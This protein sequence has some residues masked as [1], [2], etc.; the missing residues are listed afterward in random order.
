MFYLKMALKNSIN[1]MYMN[2]GKLFISSFLFIGLLFVF[3]NVKAK[4][5][6]NNEDKNRKKLSAVTQILKSDHYA[7]QV[8]NDI[9]SKKLFN[10][11]LD[12]LD[13]SKSLF[14]LED[15]QTLSKYESL[16][17][18]EING[19]APIEFYAS[20]FNIFNNKVELNLNFYNDYLSSPLQFNVSELYNPNAENEPFVANETE[21]IEKLKKHVK[22]LVLQKY[23]NEL[24]NREKTKSLPN[25]VFKTDE[26]LEVKAREE[27][28]K[29]LIKGLNKYKSSLNEEKKFEIYLNTI[30]DLFDPHTNYLPPLEKR[31]FEE[32]LSGKFYGI[33]AILAQDELGVKIGS[34]Q[35]GG[36]AWK[37][38]KIEA[39]DIVLKVSQDKNGEWT[40]LSGYEVT[41][42]VK[43]IRGGK[44]TEVRL[45][46]KKLNGNIIVVSMIREEIL[47]DE[48]YAKS[49][50]IDNKGEKIGYIKLNDFYFNYENPT[51]EHNCSQDIEV[52]IEKLKK[53]KVN[54]IILDL[55]SNGGGS[56][57]EVVKIVGM[58]I[59]QGPVVQTRDRYGRTTP[60]LDRQSG[61]IFD[62]NLAVMV[63]EYSASASEIFAAA[64]Q[65]YKRG[66][67]I[68]SPATYGKG[69][70]QRA[71]PIGDNIDNYSG[72]TDLG[73]VKMTFQKFYRI[74][75][76]STQ[77]RGVIADIVLPDE[78]QIYKIREQNN[79]HSL[80]WDEIKGLN[81]TV[82]Q[83]S[84]ETDKLIEKSKKILAS[85][86]IFTL[87]KNNIDW[88]SKNIFLPINLQFDVYKK[89][90]ER[91]NQTF[92]QNG[93]FTKLKTPLKISVTK[94]DYPKFYN[95]IDKQKQERYQAWLKSIETDKYI[96]QTVK[97][98]SKVS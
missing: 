19:A 70:V 37:S 11:F 92:N 61:T 47:I 46:V 56:L 88:L 18:D 73:V 34:V 64:I 21:R 59:D 96:G 41:E 48:I 71:F 60:Y 30:T 63:N 76:S 44:G 62:G 49:V 75:G 14:T 42:A 79:P 84:T 1:F 89:N 6:L 58:F 83:N 9:F 26:Q 15:I 31:S 80:P 20:A 66:I 8:Y 7:P 32:Q 85:D 65:D 12:E 3:S 39:N 55:R 51:G 68:G 97:I 69:T 17:D 90:T 2:K 57:A 22:Y 87:F 36:P 52:E 81:Y 13:Q 93:G 50:V 45:M 4:K 23:T 25:F 67:I 82:W 86:T 16:L 91:F 38:G 28:K 40:D 5:S 98:L 43:L 78:L 33:G 72:Q 27:V 77:N 53:E 74:N 95:N 29:N 54:S 35:P 24:D 94:D 10:A